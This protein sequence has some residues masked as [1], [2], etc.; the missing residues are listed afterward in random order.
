MNSGAAAKR[1]AANGQEHEGQLAGRLAEGLHALLQ[2][3]LLLQLA[4]AHH[5]HLAG[6]RV[7]QVHHGQLEAA[8]RVERVQ[9]RGHR[10]RHHVQVRVLLG[11]GQRH[12]RAERRRVDELLRGTGPLERADP[13]SPGA[14]P[15]RRPGSAGTAKP[16]TAII[17]PCRPRPEQARHH[18][19]QRAHRVRRPG[20]PP[21][22]AFVRPWLV[23]DISSGKSRQEAAPCRARACQR[24]SSS[25]GLVK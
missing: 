2:P 4:Q 6:G 16:A 10:A 23:S 9:R 15:P 11:D 19:G 8:H 17:I 25:A 1:N 13:S 5:Q 18:H 7:E 12:G 14:A 3:P 24:C 22:T 20:R 21:P